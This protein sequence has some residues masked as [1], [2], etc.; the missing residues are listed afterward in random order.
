M[1]AA[2][3]SKLVVLRSLETVAVPQEATA[4]TC[5]LSLPFVSKLWKLSFILFSLLSLNLLNS[6]PSPVMW[7]QISGHT[8]LSKQLSCIIM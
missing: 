6:S 1:Q 2:T 8:V 5:F 3:Q 7:M 4:R